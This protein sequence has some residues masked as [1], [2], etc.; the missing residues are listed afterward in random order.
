[1]LSSLRPGVPAIAFAGAVGGALWLAWDSV[2]RV[3]HGLD[4]SDC[5]SAAEYSGDILFALAGLFVGAALVGLAAYV[6]GSLRWV[7][8]IGGAASAV[9][10]LANGVEDCAAE[11]FFLLYVAGATVNAFAVLVLGVGIMVTGALGRWRGALLVAGALGVMQGFERGGGALFGG[12]W[13]VFALSLFVGQSEGGDAW[14]EAARTS[15][16]H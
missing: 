1:M 3:W 8:A 5:S 4:G 6:P 13:L 2:G 16:D 9:E 11:P 14:P 7:A 15:Q 10:G 12:A